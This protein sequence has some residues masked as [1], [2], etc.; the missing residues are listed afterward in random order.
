MVFRGPMDREVA[1]GRKKSHGAGNHDSI[2]RDLVPFMALG[3]NP[4]F[5]E[6]GRWL[7]RDVLCERKC[8]MTTQT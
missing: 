7:L 6:D 2:A 8:D 3:A 4:Q 5:P 1:E